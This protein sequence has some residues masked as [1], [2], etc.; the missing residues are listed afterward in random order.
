MGDEVAH[1]YCVV[2]DRPLDW[3]PTPDACRKIMK[4]WGLYPDDAEESAS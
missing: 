4:S 3:C 2:H 1:E